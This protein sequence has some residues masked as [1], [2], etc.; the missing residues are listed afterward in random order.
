M[1]KIALVSDLH[2]GV[3]KSDK[4]FLENQLNFL[5]KEFVPY[6]KQN[7]INSIAILGDLFDTR[8]TLNILM[9]SKAYNFFEYL[10]EQNIFV[11]I[12]QGNHDTYFKTTNEV[13]S[14]N[15]LKKFDNVCLIEEIELKE[16]E[17][18]KILFVPWIVN[19]EDF[20]KRVA[21]KNLHCDVCLG[22]FDIIG[23]PLNNSTI[24]QEGLET[25]LF[26]NNYTLTFSGHFHKRST[27]KRN[28]SEI[29]MIGSPYQITRNDKGNERGFCIFD[30]E[31]MNYEFVN[32][33]NTIKF[34]DLKFPEEFT[35]NQILGNVIDVYVN[36]NGNDLIDKEIQH[37][38]QRIEEYLPAYPPNIFM[39]NT[40]F[41]GVEKDIKIKSLSEM[42]DEF[43]NNLQIDNKQEIKEI[44]NELYTKSKSS[45]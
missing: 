35:S 22:H 24:C 31:T 12:F 32:S 26:L 1:S 17:N 33:E 19:Y 2:L 6:L 21:N 20:K 14:L 41:D 18:R 29:V 11:Y 30:L 28:N 45:E 4:T 7:N 37:Y 27:Y 34:I 42:I 10:K 43:I 39:N 8:N 16:I 13:H 44:I 40:L 15:F 25:N 36:Y 9:I 23:F 38:V 5:Y 3:K